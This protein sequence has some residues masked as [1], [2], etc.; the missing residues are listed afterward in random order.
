MTVPR[1]SLMLQRAAFTLIFFSIQT[2][3]TM[4]AYAIPAVTIISPKAGQ[5]SGSPVFF[6]AYATTDCAKGISAMRIYTAP[7]VNAFTTDGAHIEHFI[8]LQGGSYNAAVQAWDNCGGVSKADVALTVNSSAAVSVFLPNKTSAEWPVHITASA[9]SPNCPEGIA[10]LRIYSAPGVAAYT[11]NSATL[12]AYINLLPATHNL[13]VQAWDNCGHIFKSPLNEN[14]TASTDAFLYGAAVLNTKN[15]TGIVQLNINANGTLSN[16][17]GSGDAPL[18]VP[19]SAPNTVVVDPGGWFVYAS[20]DAGIYGFQI[21]RGNGTLK[22]IPGSPFPLNQNLGDQGPPS[23]VMDPTG[24]FIYLVYA[25]GGN[26]AD[27]LATYKID[28]S[29]GALT[30][31]GWA[32]SFGSISSGC[33]AV[34]GV[35]TNFTGQF[36]YVN[37]LPDNCSNLETF[38]FKADPN[39]RFLNTEVPGSPFPIS[40]GA[41]FAT[42]PVSTGKYL[43]LSD[44]AGVEAMS[45]TFGFS[46]DPSTGALTQTEGSPFSS[47]NI[48]QI[49]ADWKTRFLWAFEAHGFRVFT[50]D[51]ATG[52]LS[53]GSFVPQSVSGDSMVEDHTAH[54]IFISGSGVSAWS[55]S[56]NG[57]PTLLNRQ[58]ISSSNG[59]VG[60]IAVARKNPI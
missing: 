42:A 38:G 37:A 49:L 31:T 44:Q 4:A 23:I 41:F 25:G 50:I 34:T 52:A 55:A 11:I 46:I 10:A 28:R 32:R 60:S 35:T 22:V 40:A 16:P 48:F 2:L 24:N 19:K 57:T 26:A 58:N 13:T 27:G 54:F 8:T 33:T 29:S 14:V 3:F 39:T 7:G 1:S 30:W 59:S 56:S 47:E 17:N 53:P 12:D 6:E 5:N 18:F 20:S 43:Y 15:Q 51:P 21:N 9:Q 36:V 45:N